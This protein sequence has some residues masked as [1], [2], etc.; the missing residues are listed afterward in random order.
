MIAF[1]Q[2]VNLTAA[3]KLTRFEL[4]VDAIYGGCSAIRLDCQRQNAHPS[5]RPD[6]IELTGPVAICVR[7][8]HSSTRSVNQS[9][10]GYLFLREAYLKS[11]G[12]PPNQLTSVYR[13][14]ADGRLPF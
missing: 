5:C 13:N 1:V 9:V 11:S 8:S 7:T 12:T 3:A 14:P 2:S 4:A 6:G 10:T